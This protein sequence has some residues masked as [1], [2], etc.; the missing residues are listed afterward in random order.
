MRKFAIV[1]AAGCALVGLQL[2]LGTGAHGALI[3]EDVKKA[4][5]KIA[6]LIKAGDDAGAKKEAA[7]LAKK[8]EELNDVMHGFKKRNVKKGIKG[9]GYGPKPGEFIPDGIEG[10]IQDIARDGITPAALK[11]EVAHLEEA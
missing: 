10:K 1:C 8:V 5:D 11:K 3:D 9:L 4:I 7:A 2:L 6:G